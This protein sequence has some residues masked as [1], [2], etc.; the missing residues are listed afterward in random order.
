MTRPNNTQ[1]S[2][3]I[4]CF[5]KHNILIWLPGCN[6]PKTY[7]YTKCETTQ[8]ELIEVKPLEYKP[9]NFLYIKS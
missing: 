9:S 2:D 5:R 8:M 1:L 3:F 4:A 6:K 7:Y